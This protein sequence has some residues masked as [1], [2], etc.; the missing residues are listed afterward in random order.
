[1]SSPS[2]KGEPQSPK[3]GPHQSHRWVRARGPA[4]LGQAGRRGSF[5]IRASRGYTVE[6]YRDR[7]V[8]SGT[9]V[10]NSVAWSGA[11][12]TTLLDTSN[13]G[14]WHFVV[15]HMKK[16]AGNTWRLKSS[17]D[18]G[19]YVD[20]GNSTSGAMPV[21]ASDSD[22]YLRYDPFDGVLDE[23]GCG[24]SRAVQHLPGERPVQLGGTGRRSASTPRRWSPLRPRAPRP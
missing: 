22:F 16:N 7:I 12:V 21:S 4:F 24:S 2:I 23:F 1:V 15:S 5:W 20:H 10:A 3:L 14:N 19:V 8:A 13:D 11:S 17:I 9:T 18:N 6:F